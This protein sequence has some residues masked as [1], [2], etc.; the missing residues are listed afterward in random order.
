[1]QYSVLFI[2]ITII[3]HRFHYSI[4]DNFKSTDIHMLYKKGITGF[5]TR[6]FFEIVIAYKKS[7][8]GTFCNLSEY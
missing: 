5:F 7:P 8:R 2:Y 6:T 3:L 1:M 4:G